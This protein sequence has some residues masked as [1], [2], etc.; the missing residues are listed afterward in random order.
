MLR[1]EFRIVFGCPLFLFV[2]LAFCQLFLAG[3]AFSQTLLTLHHFNAQSG[4]TIPL[5]GSLLA[6]ASG[7]L[8]GATYYGGTAN[9]GTVFE[10]SPPTSGGAWTET[11]LYGFAGG[12]DGRSPFAS[13]VADQAG[14]LYGSTTYGGTTGD[15]GIVF[16][17]VRPTTTGGAWV[18]NVLY[19]FQGG[20]NDGTYPSG[21]LIFDGAGNL[22]GETGFGG[23]CNDGTVFE[24]SPP[25][26]QGG[27]GRK[28]FCTVSN[29]RATA[30][31]GTRLVVGWFLARVA[32]YSELRLSAPQ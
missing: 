13:L 29:T 28:R 11:V 5:Q 24:L 2:A 25:A 9:D 16:Q 27:H 10:L 17:L 4:G 6:D 7:N 18:E 32:L 19:R 15:N 22:Y 31:T 3:Q 30:K 1:K 21:G 20:S 26:S 8:Y 14:N 12:T 23:A